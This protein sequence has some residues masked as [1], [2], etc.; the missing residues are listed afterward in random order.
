MTL[1]FECINCGADFEFEFNDLLDKPEKL[2]CPNCDI[3]ADVHSVEDLM[4]ALDDV[5]ANVKNIRR[6]FRLSFTLESDDLPP[7]YGPADEHEAD[8]WADE[9]IE[10]EPEEEDEQ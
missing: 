2:K 10:E 3:R 4:G 1:E 6:K 9:K 5:C 8:N 7:P